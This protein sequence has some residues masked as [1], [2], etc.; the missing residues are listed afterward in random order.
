[1]VVERQIS[2]DDMEKRIITVTERAFTTTVNEA[3]QQNI[4]SAASEWGKLDFSAISR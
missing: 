3:I 4:I 1:L 2:V